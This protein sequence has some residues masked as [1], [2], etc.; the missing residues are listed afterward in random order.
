ML[1]CSVGSRAYASPIDARVSIVLY[2]CPI[3]SEQS[4]KVRYRAQPS[5]WPADETVAQ[6]RA[7]LVAPGVWHL[8]SLLPLGHWYLRVASEHCAAFLTTDSVD[9]EDRAFLTG[10]ISGDAGPLY[11]PKGYLTVVLPYDG[12]AEM[13]WLSLDCSPGDKALW[14]VRSGRHFYFA[15]VWP[16]NYCLVYYIADGFNLTKNVHIPRQGM[17]IRITSQQIKAVL[18][19]YERISTPV[20]S[21][22]PP[23]QL[24]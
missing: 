23:R 11:E 17:T 21:P 7:T 9:G 3:D 12:E 15:G 10:T 22:T 14:P 8:A 6:T 13:M 2:S 1:A 18:E 24:R 4:P 19:K 5:G 16:G 20:A